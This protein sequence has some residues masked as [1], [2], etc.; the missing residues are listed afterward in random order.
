MPFNIWKHYIYGRSYLWAILTT[1]GLPVQDDERNEDATHHYFRH[2]AGGTSFYKPESM[3]VRRQDQEN[4]INVPAPDQE[5][6]QVMLRCWQKAFAFVERDCNPRC[7]SPLMEHTE[8]QDQQALSL[9]RQWKPQELGS[10]NDDAF[11]ES[12]VVSSNLWR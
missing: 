4:W 12:Q 2:W 3:R 6:W 7:Y 10:L 11:G 8:H 9:G 1:G 5:G